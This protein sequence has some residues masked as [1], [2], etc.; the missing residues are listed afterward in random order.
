ML[1][2]LL[3]LNAVI[4]TELIQI[5]ENTSAIL[6]KSPPPPVAS[7]S[8]TSCGKPRLRWQKSTGP[9]HARP[10]HPQTPVTLLGNSAYGNADNTPV[11]VPACVHAAAIIREQSD[12]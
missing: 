9:H 2:D 7:P 4:A 1:A 12:K 11:N 8:T 5:T 3:W 10:A 6:R